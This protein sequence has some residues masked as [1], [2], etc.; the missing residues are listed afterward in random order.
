MMFP[1]LHPTPK[2][3]FPLISATATHWVAVG[4]AF[5]YFVVVNCSASV[6]PLR[7]VVEE[8]PP[9][10]AMETSS[11]YPVPTSRW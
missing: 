10:M 11:K 7:A 2:D 9:L 4:L 5:F 3:W 6:D 1:P 8:V